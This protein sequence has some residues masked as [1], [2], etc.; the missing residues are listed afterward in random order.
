[1]EKES[2]DGSD[3]YGPEVRELEVSTVDLQDVTSGLTEHVHA[4]TN[5]L[6][7][8]RKENILL[9]YSTPSDQSASRTQ[10]STALWCKNKNNTF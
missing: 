8:Y 5:P 10:N 3:T 2:Q 9:L 1:M 4:E 6:L 7:K